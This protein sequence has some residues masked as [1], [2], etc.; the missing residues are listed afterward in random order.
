MWVITSEFA[1]VTGVSLDGII[2]GAYLLPTSS[3]SPWEVW[4][5]WKQHEN[6]KLIYAQRISLFSRLQTNTQRSVWIFPVVHCSCRR[7]VRLMRLTLPKCLHERKLYDIQWVFS[8]IPLI[9]AIDTGASTAPIKG[10]LRLQLLFPA[11][12]QDVFFRSS[13]PCEGGE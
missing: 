8:V 3:Q 10:V 2:K 4:E 9:P 7:V 11:F 5:F 6:V 12:F 13:L 1:F